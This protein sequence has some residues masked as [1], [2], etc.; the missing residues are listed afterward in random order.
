[1]ANDVIKYHRTIATYVNT[2]IGSGFQISKLL[3]PGPTSEMLIEKPEWKDER[4][5]PLFLLIAAA[6]L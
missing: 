6:R 5:R 3:E 1:M 2:L 4:R